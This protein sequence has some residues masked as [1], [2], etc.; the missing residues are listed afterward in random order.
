MTLTL[1]KSWFWSM[2]ARRSTSTP[3]LCIAQEE[4]RKHHVL[5]SSGQAQTNLDWS[6]AALTG[7]AVRALMKQVHACS[8]PFPSPYN[9]HRANPGHNRGDDLVCKIS[10]DREVCANSACFN[11]LS[12]TRLHKAFN[13]SSTYQILRCVVDFP[14]HS[15][16]HLVW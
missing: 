5:D 4:W 8:S 9:L 1:K 14:Q 10:L 6:S 7:T 11:L 13:R 2:R 3:K 16:L 15:Y 12:F